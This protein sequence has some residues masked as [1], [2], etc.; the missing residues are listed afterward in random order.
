V[1][2]IERVREA[3]RAAIEGRDDVA[4]V[5]L[6]GSVARGDARPDSDV[7]LGV[8]YR[9]PSPDRAHDEVAVL[10]AD[11]VERATGI[12][13]VDVVDLE[14]QGP[15]FA[16]RALCEAVR[17]VVRDERRRVDFESDAI[18]RGI[19]F[20]PTLELATAGKPSALRRWLAARRA[21]TP[22]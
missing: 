16:H 9:R 21:G 13:R 6:F 8:V 5:Y 17:L 1:E 7:D 10:L 4:V 11:A 18:V 12:P 3:A 22:A 19:D 15:A 14:A 2:T 20:A